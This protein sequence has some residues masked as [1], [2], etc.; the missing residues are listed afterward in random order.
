MIEINLLPEDLKIKKQSNQPSPL[1]NLVYL[2]PLILFVVVVAHLYLGLVFISRSQIL[3]GLERKW[4]TLEPQRQEVQGMK[5]EINA[6]SS[7]ARIVQGY[8]SSRVLIAP[9]LNKLS[10]GLQPGIWFNSVTFGRSSLV[11]KASVV[12]LKMDEMA[13][14][15]TFWENLKNDKD[16][17]ADF[18]SVELGAV[19]RRLVGSYDVVD[20][21]LT[22]AITPK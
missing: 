13:V 19:Q 17:R 15:N 4:K 5:S 16:F 6:G 20:F 8:L 1:D 14:I 7:D 3:A 10:L 18:S 9:K 12:S 22:A 11:V 21:V 2:I